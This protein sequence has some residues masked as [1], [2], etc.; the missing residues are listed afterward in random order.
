M[1]TRNTFLILFGSLVTLNFFTLFLLFIQLDSQEKQYK[2]QVNRF[3]S[4]S[5][6]NKLEQGSEDLTDYSRTFVITGDTIW[7]K[8]YWNLVN[9]RDGI[10]N[11]EFYIK[12]LLDS[13]LEMGFNKSEF[14][15]LEEALNHSDELVLIEEE[16]MNAS[17][18]LFKDSSGMYTIIDEP[19]LNYA[20]NKLYNDEYLLKVNQIMAPIK[21]FDELTD[22]RTKN[23]TV[24]SAKHNKKLLV[25]IITFKTF[26]ILFLILVYYLISKRI[27]KEEEISLKLEKSELQFRTLVNS[28]PG[29]IYNC[30]TEDPWQMFF[31]TDQIEILSGYPKEDFSGDKP[32]RT[33][34]EIMHPDDR[35]KVS[36]IVK[37]AIK[38]KT[39][40]NL[41]YRIIHKNKSIQYVNAHGKAIYNNDGSVN[42]LV[43]GI[44]NETEKKLA[45]LKLNASELQFKS[46][47]ATM[48]GAIYR[49][50]LGDP[51]EIYQISDEIENFTGYP[52][53]DFLGPKPLRVYADFMHSDDRK[54][55]SN[56]VQEAIDKKEEYKIEYRVIHKDGYVRYVA[57]YGKA[58]YKA[59]GTPDYLVGAI[60]NDTENKKTRIQLEESELK[61]K[62][63]VTNLPGVI[64]S[65]GVDDPWEMY[66][67]TDTIETLS[68]YPKE[69]FLGINPRRNFGDIMHPDDRKKASEDV[70]FAINNKQAFKIDYRV[71]HKDGSEH[72][73]YG[74]GHAM[75]ND[76]GSPDY[77]VGGIFDDSERLAA[78]KEVKDSEE[79]FQ[80]AAKGSNAGIW[81][82]DVATNIAFWT[83]VHYELLGYEVD[84]IEPTLSFV[85]SIVYADDLDV[86]DH[87]VNS[88]IE[89]GTPLDFEARFYTK[90]NEIRWFRSRGA[91][92]RDA[93]GKSVRIVGTFS[94]IT[95]KKIAEQKLE[96]SEQTAR[97]LLNATSDI[98][99][100]IDEDGTILELNDAMAQV[101][102]SKRENLIGSN[103]FDTMPKDLAIQRKE[104]ISQVIDEEKPLKIP[105]D[106]GR[107]GQIYDSGIYPIISSTHEKRKV[108]VY[109]HDISDLVKT[110]KALEAKEQQLKYALEASNE[111]IWEWNL[112][113][114][115]INYSRRCF[116]LIGYD[117]VKNIEEVEAFWKSVI[118]QE[119]MK[120]A[121]VNNLEQITKS[122]VHDSIYRVKTRSNEIKWIHTKGKAVEFLDD[123]KPARI[124]GTMSDITYRMKQEEKVVNAILETEDKE[125][126]RIAR[127]IHDGLQQTMST[128]LMSFE[129][130]RSSVDFQD[131]K[132]YDKFHEGYQY[133]KKSI[134]ESRT[135]AHNL[136]PKVIG[137]NGIVSGIE[138]LISAIES[139]SPTK[140]KFEQN[141]NNE[142]L[143]LTEE[144]TFYR[145]VQES[146][147]NVIKYANAKTCT[148]QLLK[149]ED[150]VLLTIEDNGEG[151]ELSKK[152]N[153]FG[154]NSMKTRAES[155]GAYF[156]IN[157]Q[158]TRGTQILVELPLNS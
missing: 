79:R 132:I 113:T 16:A 108:V 66:Y 73:V 56:A 33:F 30:A 15:L 142:R 49:S 63:L 82:L 64:Y 118:H 105:Y 75:Y 2:S 126:S 139:S 84:E 141:L 102:G 62:S 101:L 9:D 110:Q 122:G 156:E 18:G 96:Q 74:Y 121:L 59:N 36:D 77:L 119:D 83:D 24:E 103:I 134:E 100:L 140:F 20:L 38:N 57:D 85:R 133:L 70:Q 154:L 130:V 1:K 22:I 95:D 28:L 46:L 27:K 99:H 67:M 35:Q 39:T 90:T 114:S 8:K 91:S 150:V 89:Q 149:Y 7:E 54:Y 124:L 153:T 128:A 116:N 135:L 112:K 80:L 76:D 21:K 45:E 147:N 69:D 10:M 68:G 143:K 34:G 107:G 53:E 125:R 51:W 145:I 123:G 136:M 137:R 25:A 109:A 58:I 131:Q 6:G 146:I 98:S 11:D 41:S 40:Y 12:S 155:I 14:E 138:S 44:F 43:G 148:I 92:S 152:Q 17:K 86:F 104:L 48:P 97:V 94:D 13:M 127:D 37:E 115:S 129:K 72:Y 42:Y 4:Y 5:I 78:I 81:D 117:Q 3:N 61:F 111:G 31:I 23:E 29:T 55:V 158:K 120:D 32:R 151:F 157:S 26:V 65:C 71:I 93:H 87:V 144:M 50:G 19:D 88:H 60:F 106:L 47:V 52:K